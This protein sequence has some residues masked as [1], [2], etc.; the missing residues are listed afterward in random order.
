MSQWPA[1][2]VLLDRVVA[3]LQVVHRFL[4]TL[5]HLQPRFI[6]WKV[7]RPE[8]SLDGV[9]SVVKQLPEFSELRSLI[10]DV[11][12]NLSAGRGNGPALT[13]RSPERTCF[14]RSE[15]FASLK[16]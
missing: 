1:F 9:D 11:G 13:G 6:F 10:L 3:R 2:E 8:D 5:F 15:F 4:Q 7:P 14:H 12:K 16:I